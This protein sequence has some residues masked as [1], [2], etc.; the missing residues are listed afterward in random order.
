MSHWL[1]VTISPTFFEGGLNASNLQ[2]YLPVFLTHNLCDGTV[3]NGVVLTT[4]SWESKG[5]FHMFNISMT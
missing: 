2:S 1:S 4:T 5:H 3:K